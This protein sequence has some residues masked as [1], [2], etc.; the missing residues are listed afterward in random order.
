MGTSAFQSGAHIDI[1]G[2]RYS[3]LR[4]VTDDQWQL[5]DFRT[6]R[7]V[8]YSNN[9]LQS[10]YV[11][12]ELTFVARQ[13]RENLHGNEQTP[14]LLFTPQQ[15]EEAKMR[16][17]Y[18]HAVLETTGT[19]AQIAPIVKAVWERIRKPEAIPGLSS[20]LRWKCA[21]L[22]SGKNITSLVEQTHKKGNGSARYP[23]EVSAI[24]LAAIDSVYLTLEKNT[25]QEVIDRVTALVNRE[26]RLRPEGLQLPTPTRRFIRRAIDAIPAFDRYS[27]RHGRVAATK[28]FRSVQAHRTTLAPLERAEID[29]TLLDLMCIDDHTGLPLG[30]PYI[31]A[32]IDDYSRCL[33]GLYVGFEPPSY[34]TVAHCLKHAF[35]PKTDLA[36]KYPGIKNSWDAHGVMRELVVDNG[37]EFHSASLE[38]ACYS[39]GIEIHYSARKTPWFKGKIERFLG[40]LNGAVAHGN[41]GTTFRNI[42]DKEEY[43]PSKHAVIRLGKLQEIIRMWVVDVY[44][45]K[46]HRTLNAPPAIVWQ[47]SIR[48]EDILLPDD[49]A[50]LDA[51][52]GRSEERRLTHK[53][54]EINCMF[55]NSPE[56]TDLRRQFGDK[57]DVEIRV[58][59]ADLGQIIVFSPDKTQM[60]TANVL[61][62]EYANGLSAWQHRVCKKFAAQELEKYDP[63]AWL[64]AKMAIASLIEEE[65]MHKKQKSRTKIA[66]F[67]GENP[68][69]PAARQV[70]PAPEPASPAPKAE[71]L[72]HEDIA[73][74]LPSDRPAKRFKPVY[75]ERGQS[76]IEADQADM[77]GATHG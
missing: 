17:A 5:E 54:I 50:Q 69:L 56:L 77:L 64:E 58:N 41:P 53:G 40:T 48:P 14:Q 65:F 37:A 35:L 11:S 71:P 74:P 60:Y 29:H 19:R 6:K 49:P 12:G 8:E 15:W 70:I 26:N 44:H 36:E 38:N 23:Q 31:T 59:D 34:L 63:T 24:V 76:M 20:V 9:E 7:I 46:I 27:A 45:Q 4:R 66:R 47:N 43:D 25:V 39:L 22:R 28:K 75:R 68:P 42:F 21:Y 13:N 57:L 32:C 2:K 33:L 3:L 72:T 10:Q 51:I 67:K 61:T 18:V 1:D 62:P 16:R 30:R 73:V 55:Y 52:M